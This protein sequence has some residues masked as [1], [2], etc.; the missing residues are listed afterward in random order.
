MKKRLLVSFSGGETSAFMAYWIWKHLQGEYEIIFVFANTGQENEETLMFVKRCAEL[1]GIEV[2]WVEA[3]VNIVS[4]QGTG[5]KIVT[6]ETASRNGEPFELVIKKYGIPNMATPH[7]TRELKQNPIKSYAKSIGWKHYYTAIGIRI[8]EIDRMNRKREEMRFIYP[9][10]D[11]KMQP[12]SKQKINFWWSQQPFRLELKGYQ[13]NCL[14]CWKKGDQKLYQ[15]AKE[16]EFAFNFFSIMESKYG[17]YVPETRLKL[18]ADKGVLPTFP[19][20]FF[21]KKRS[22]IDII[23]ESKLWN[24]KIINDAEI[25]KEAP[26]LFNQTDLDGESCEVFSECKQS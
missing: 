12:M 8:D 2:I 16:N 20:T 22:A 17:K 21:R 7:C 11:S 26:N 10:I 3:D 23:N 1:F 6:Y 5:H 18:M 24:G 9:L 4:G 14:V 15:I 13:G 19:I 25:V